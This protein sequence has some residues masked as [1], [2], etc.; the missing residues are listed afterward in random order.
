M[1][2]AALSRP[3]CEPAS[4]AQVG[5]R[6]ERSPVAICGPRWAVNELAIRNLP[7]FEGVMAHAMDAKPEHKGAGRTAFAKYR[8]VYR[9]SR[10]A[11]RE[12]LRKAWA[13]RRARAAAQ[14]G[15]TVSRST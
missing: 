4:A 9:A 2:R 13:M 10:E 15:R 3:W 8:A 5:R 1:R 12:R 6:C 7:G 11:A 14:Q